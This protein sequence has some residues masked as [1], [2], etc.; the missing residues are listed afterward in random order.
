MHTNKPLQIARA[1]YL[2]LSVL[3]CILGLTL[4]FYPAFPV[5][6]L[7]QVGSALLISFGI[8]KLIGYLSKDL[9]RLAFQFD[10]A[11]GLFYIALGILLLRHASQ[12]LR[13]VSV[14][15]S[16]C[17]LADALLKVQISVD[18]RQFG[19]GRWWMILS[20]ACLTG[21]VGFLLL[22]LPHAAVP[23]TMIHLGV[24]LLLEGILNLITTLLAVQV[25]RKK[26]PAAPAHHTQG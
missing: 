14:P 18:A 2:V 17:I 23:H 15:V 4:I 9:Y 16:L 7:C 10:L 19:I 26:Q 3:F 12:V 25:L 6:V 20:A 21:T 13:Y 8:V 22:F 24:C 5:P 11:F 1:G